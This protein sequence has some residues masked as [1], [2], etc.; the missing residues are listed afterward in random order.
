MFEVAVEHSFAAAHFLRDYHGKCERLHG[1]NYK[2]QVRVEGP[3][4]DTSG[5]LVDFVELKQLVRHATERLDHQFLNEMAPFDVVN[6]SAENIA[7]YLF[8]EISSGL[9]NDRGAGLS[10]VKVWE[11]DKQYACYRPPVSNGTIIPSSN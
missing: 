6:P 4:L 8:E 5:M 2:V 11:T 9:K 7:R 1:H 3:E 10:E